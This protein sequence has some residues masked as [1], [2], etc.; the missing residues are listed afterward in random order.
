MLTCALSTANNISGA[1]MNEAES[2]LEG[3]GR[4]S[5]GN[6]G[7]EIEP[8]CNYIFKMSVTLEP[9]VADR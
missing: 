2:C 9:H 3:A 1:F 5:Y 7:V 6:L 8:G 4:L